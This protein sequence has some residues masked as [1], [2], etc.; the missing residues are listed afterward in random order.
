VSLSPHT[1]TARQGLLFGGEY[2]IPGLR[3]TGQIYGQITGVPLVD[4][5]SLSYALLLFLATLCSLDRVGG[6]TSAGMGQVICHVTL[7]SIDGHRQQQ[8]APSR[9]QRDTD[10]SDAQNTD[11]LQPYLEWLPGFEFY[12][13]A[14]EELDNPPEAAGETS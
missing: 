13:L 6:G 12:A 11:L 4:K 10:P 3:F 7:L 14:L 9:E 5:P 1:R 8:D 2:S